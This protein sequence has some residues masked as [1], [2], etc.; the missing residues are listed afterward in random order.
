MS[1]GQNL[2]DNFTQP[3]TFLWFSF[4]ITF[5]TCTKIFSSE[6]NNIL[7]SSLCFCYY[8][9]T[10]V[11]SGSYLWFPRARTVLSSSLTWLMNS[12]ILITPCHWQYLFLCNI[13]TS[14]NLSAFSLFLTLKTEV[15]A[16]FKH[17][18]ISKSEIFFELVRQY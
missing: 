1:D 10:W 2:F 17:V 3:S 15:W 11:W 14:S 13:I 8:K 5:C 7:G 16:S 9:I 18:I 12:G 4:S 6:K